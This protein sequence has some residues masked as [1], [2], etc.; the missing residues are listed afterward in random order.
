MRIAF[1]S[2]E[3]PPETA[4][5]G[6]ATYVG[7][8]ARCL[9]AADHDVE[10]FCGGKS[11]NPTY[12]REGVRIHRLDVDRMTFPHA[13]V[14]VF[15]ARHEEK[16]FQV[17]EGPDFLGEARFVAKAYPQLPY[18]VRLHTPFHITRKLNRPEKRPDR[19]LK[20]VRA[21]WTTVRKAKPSGLGSDSRYILAIERENIGL[22]HE[23]SA[24][25]E[26]IAKLICDEWKVP[27]SR[28]SIVPFPFQPSPALLANPIPQQGYRV[29]FVGRLEQR[30]GVIDLARAIPLILRR[31]PQAQF[32]FVGEPFPAPAPHRDMKEYLE[33]EL[34]AYSSN[35]TFTGKVSPAEIPAQLAEMDICVFPSLW[36][37]FGL[38]V[39]EAIAAGRAV[40]C[41]DNGGMAE[42]VDG[43]E[44]GLLVPPKNPEAIAAK[45]IHLLAHQAQRAELARRA[46][47]DVLPRFA[48]ARVIQDQTRSYARATSACNCNPRT[49]SVV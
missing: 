46:R 19:F 36:E 20:S 41:T 49:L 43:G 34:A 18:V 26:A 8:I 25:T 7:Q 37:S 32:R 35:V 1:V 6:I 29:G 11:S 21:L 15:R 47:A 23:I 27:A 31:F 39:L 14:K 30:K 45:V 4:L 16:P 38:V 22:A 9:A 28:I 5:G 3:Y 44:Y 17:M 40:V 10:V 24:P 48:P 42:I 13:V 2:Y 12:V 33:H